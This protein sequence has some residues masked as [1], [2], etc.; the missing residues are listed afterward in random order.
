MG[1]MFTPDALATN[2]GLLLAEIVK[3]G[4]IRT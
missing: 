4:R 3:V 1:N 2:L